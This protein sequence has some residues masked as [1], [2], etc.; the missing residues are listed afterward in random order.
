[1]LV[2]LKVVFWI[3]VILA[4][5]GALGW[6]FRAALVTLT[7][8]NIARMIRTAPVPASFGML[9]IVV[10]VVIAAIFAPVLAP[11]GEREVVGAAVPAVELRAL[12]RHRQS[13]AATCS[14]G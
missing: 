14:R 8:R 10:Y 12:A 4:V 11:Y 6:L 1:M 7:P 5:A 3:A 13:R 9:V 2:A